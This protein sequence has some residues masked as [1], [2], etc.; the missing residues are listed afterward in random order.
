MK[1]RRD[2][3]HLDFRA[4]DLVKETDHSLKRKVC[5]CFIPK[6][7]LRVRALWEGLTELPRADTLTIAAYY[8][9]RKD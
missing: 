1:A 5:E 2:R 7:I 6:T 4:Q 3:I 8:S 9:E